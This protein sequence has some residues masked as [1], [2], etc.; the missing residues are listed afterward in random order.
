MVA[1]I[2]TAPPPSGAKVGL[3][4][5]HQ[6]WTWYCDPFSWKWRNVFKVEGNFAVHVK[7]MIEFFVPLDADGSAKDRTDV[8]NDFL[9][10][11]PLLFHFH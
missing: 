6:I 2:W 11:A 7:E 8:K 3:L 9:V 10:S 1:S 4:D 5:K